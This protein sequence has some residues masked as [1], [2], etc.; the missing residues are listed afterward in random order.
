MKKDLEIK[1][2]IRR[3][4]IRGKRNLLNLSLP[5]KKTPVRGDGRLASLRYRKRRYST[6]PFGVTQK[7]MAKS[8]ER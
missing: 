5:I 7:S 8:P 1:R 4:S 6:R 2:G 3:K